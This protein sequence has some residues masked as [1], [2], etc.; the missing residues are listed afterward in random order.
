VNYYFDIL[1]GLG[2]LFDLLS[3][4]IDPTGQW[5][6]YSSSLQGIMDLAAK[7][8]QTGGIRNQGGEGNQAG[9]IRD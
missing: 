2:N 6:F 8:N 9:G 1:A 7:E 5:I 3:A 4:V